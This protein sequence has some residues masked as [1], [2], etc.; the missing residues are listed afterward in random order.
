VLAERTRLSRRAILKQ[1]CL[2]LYPRDPVGYCEDILGLTLTDTQRRI[3]RLVLQPP[4]KILVRAA[5]NVGKSLLAAAL[6][7]WWYDCHDP[8]VCLSTAPSDK[9]VTRILWKE[10]R[11]LRSRLGGFA[12]PA[13]PLLQRRGEPH[14]FA[15]GTVARSAEGFQGQHGAAIFIVLDEAVGVDSAFWTSAET[16]LGGDSYG[17]LAIFNPTDTSSYAYQA[18]MMGGWH[19]VEMNATDHPNIAAGLAGLPLPVPN[20]I[21]FGRLTEMLEAWSTPVQG[22]TQPGDIEWPPGSG[23]WLRPGPDA[24]A[25]CLGRWPS[26]AVN[27]VWGEA[28]WQRCCMP[29]GEDGP[30]EVGCDVARFGD[31]ATVAFVRKGPSV[32]DHVRRVKQDTSTTARMLADLAI[33]WGA[34]Y[35]LDPKQVPVKID[36]AGVGGGVT[37][38]GRANGYRFVPCLGASRALNQRLYPNRRSE[39][40]FEVRDMAHAGKVSV[41]RL[42]AAAKAEIQRQLMGVK[43]Q[44]N[45]AGQRQVEEKKVTKERLKKSPDEADAF[46]LAYAAEGNVAKVIT[47]GGG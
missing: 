23:R 2:S 3:A 17:L 41:S 12:G 14:H 22:P 24:E 4:H 8:G 6:I 9:Q 32:V 28:D 45:G 18:E 35:R 26:S 7:S 19:V 30:L 33:K 10:L 42:P 38:Q 31:D 37:D 15:A 11:G 47:V 46:L 5:H 36:D 39:S 13:A 25:K 44:L 29:A 27:S 20:A 1:L 16:M 40:W 34:H 43:Y 21:R